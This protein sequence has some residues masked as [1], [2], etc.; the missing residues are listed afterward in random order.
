MPSKHKNA[1]KQKKMELAQS[2]FDLVGMN[3]TQ[4][5]RLAA[6]V[7]G[8]ALLLFCLRKVTLADAV[9]AVA[10]G[11]LIYRGVTDRS[12]NIN[13]EAAAERVTEKIQ[14]VT[15]R[16]KG[17]ARGLWS[18]IGERFS[19]E[20]AP[21][22]V[23]Q[24]IVINR[25]PEA[26]YAFWRDLENLPSVMSHL[27]SVTHT[28]GKRSHWVA[29]GPAGVPIE[30]DAEITADK[31]NEM[32]SW[33]ALEDADVPNQ[34][35]VYFEKTADGQTELRVSLEY[36]PP[37]G[38]I[39]AAVAE[40]FGEDPAE[41]IEEDLYHFKEAVE[42]GKLLETETAKSRASEGEA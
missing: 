5:E 19:G 8:G 21:I 11:S 40:F 17:W 6:V 2:E 26:L 33:R 14:D 23:E 36:T 37:G 22:Q 41:K 20:A 24:S 13:P 39:G 25:P 28:R 38:E 16:A 35:S 3:V 42:E 12:M 32:I 31:K 4:V 30:W 34:G 10:G 18:Q 29:K 9:L 1:V 15:D 27:E 7:G